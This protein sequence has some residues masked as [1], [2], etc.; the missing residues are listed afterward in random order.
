MK[1]PYDDPRG[2]LLR[3]STLEIVFENGS[4]LGI[5]FFAGFRH[6]LSSIS[7]RMCHSLDTDASVF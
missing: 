3:Q 6:N 1:A 7:V 5:L 2:I 4:D